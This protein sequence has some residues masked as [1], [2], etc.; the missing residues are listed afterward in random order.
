MGHAIS[1]EMT[2]PGVKGIDL[3]TAEGRQQIP[4]DYDQWLP[5]AAKTYKISPHP[6]DYVMV[7][8]P[9]CPSDLPNRN[10]VGF[11]LAELVGMRPPPHHQQVFKAW[12]R[13]PVHYEHR[14]EIPTDA[15]GVIFDTEMRRI[16]GYGHGRLWKVMGLLGID[17]NKNPD[18][19]ARVLRGD[20]NTYSMGAL[21][22]YFTC[23]YCGA[24][25]GQCPHLNPKADLDFKSLRD[26]FTGVETLAFRNA[27]VLSPIEVSIVEDP[28]W[29][30]ALSDQVMPFLQQRGEP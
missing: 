1:A 21:C 20:V 7:T 11:P 4:L 17:K 24:R 5:Y 2:T 14:N 3:D 23:S 18:M 15:Y 9:I 28:A 26:P 12:K 8:T 30:T 19:A 13:C 22:D 25:L 6:E 29:T 16:Q 27:H 10:G